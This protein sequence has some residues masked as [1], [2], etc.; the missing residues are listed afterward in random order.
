M[1]HSRHSAPAVNA[2]SMADIAFLLLI[3]FLVT[4]TISA[5]MGINRKLPEICPPGTNCNTMINERNILRININASDELFVK[6]D[7]ISIKDLKQIAKNFLDNNGDNSCSYCNGLKDATLSDN[8]T[9]AVISLSNDK[10]TSYEMYI[11][12]Q[13]ILTQAYYELREDYAT[14]VLRKNAKDL[15]ESDLKAIK[16]AYPF[17]ISE[18]E[19]RR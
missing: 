15:T 6:D 13:D 5:D 7:V 12:V 14:S 8:P 4:T 3:F 11:A 2:G 17:K 18:A 1:K 16:Q 9:E 19:T 10:D